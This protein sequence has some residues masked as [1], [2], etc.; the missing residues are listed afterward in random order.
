MA[1]AEAAHCSCAWAMVTSPKAAMLIKVFMF[2]TNTRE[3]M[4]GSVDSA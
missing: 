4:V 2:E 1:A 3:W